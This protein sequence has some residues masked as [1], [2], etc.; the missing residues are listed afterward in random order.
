MQ[1]GEGR[2]DRERGGRVDS[3][4]LDSG[5]GVGNG[6][7]R[8]RRH[9]VVDDRTTRTQTNNCHGNAKI[10]LGVAM[11]ERGPVITI[12]KWAMAV[13]HQQATLPACWTPKTIQ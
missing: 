13:G 1:R 5:R 7:D 2:A 9:V 11:L 10:G 4:G 8:G 12:T 3:N 6:L